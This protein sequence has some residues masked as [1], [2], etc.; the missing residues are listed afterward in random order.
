MPRPTKV[1]LFYSGRGLKLRK[2]NHLGEK[3][4][5]L[6]KRNVAVDGWIGGEEEEEERRLEEKKRREGGEKGGK[7]GRSG[8]RK[9]RRKVVGEQDGGGDTRRTDKESNFRGYTSR[10]Y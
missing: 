4:E 2:Y 6:G 8:R 3:G 9:R 7:G 5:K 10:N 1:G